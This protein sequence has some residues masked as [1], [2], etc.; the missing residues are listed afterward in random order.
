[1]GSAQGRGGGAIPVRANERQRFRKEKPQVAM[2]CN[3][4]S[5]CYDRSSPRIMTCAMDIFESTLIFWCL[6]PNVFPRNEEK[7]AGSM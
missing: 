5:S 3:A 6:L 1:M 7:K 4:L 2:Q